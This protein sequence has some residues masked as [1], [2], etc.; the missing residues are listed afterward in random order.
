MTTLLDSEIKYD[1]ETRDYAVYIGGEL[2]GYGRNYH[3]AEQIRTQALWEAQ[4]DMVV[5]EREMRS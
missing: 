4:I 1:R 3:D 5:T 2:I